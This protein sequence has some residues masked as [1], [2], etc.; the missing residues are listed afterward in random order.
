[1]ETLTK[2]Y[3]SALVINDKGKILLQLK[4][5]SY[6]FWPNRLAT[7]GGG[8]KDF[9]SPRTCMMREFGIE[10]LVKLK[11]FVYFCEQDFSDESKLGK[12][13]L[14]EG[15]IYYFSARISE[16]DA[17]KI[18]VTEGVGHGFFSEEELKKK[19]ELGQIIPYQ[20]EIIGKFLDS[21]K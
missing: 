1:M 2:N 20:H 3:T 5:G 11:N 16:N 17:G 19:N 13:I 9:E 6:P 8:I 14:R 15:R 10:T 21:L 7:F 4:D 18:R 12:K